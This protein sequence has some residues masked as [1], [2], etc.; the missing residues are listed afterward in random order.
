MPVLA[1]ELPDLET[2][3]LPQTS[4]ADT[5]DSPGPGSYEAHL[6]ANMTYN[7]LK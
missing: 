3:S 1:D 5:L 7:D 2:K 6:N 4:W